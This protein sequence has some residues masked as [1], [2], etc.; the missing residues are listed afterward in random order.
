MEQRGR[1]PEHHDPRHAADAAASA[2]RRLVGL[3]QDDP[4]LQVFTMH[5]L[6]LEAH[7]RGSHAE[8]S[9]TQLPC[10]RDALQPLLL[11]WGTAISRVACITT[12]LLLLRL[13]LL[14]HCARSVATAAGRCTLAV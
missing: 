9:A 4:H 2:R 3:Q 14:L 5:S 1:R 6:Q 13:L 7:A 12:V 10:T 11:C 8:S